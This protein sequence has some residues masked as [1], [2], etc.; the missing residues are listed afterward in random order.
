MQYTFIEISNGMNID[1]TKMFKNLFILPYKH[2][3]Q[4]R[5]TLNTMM[6]LSFINRKKEINNLNQL[7]TWFVANLVTTLD[8]SL[9]FHIYFLIY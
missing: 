4:I 2:Q 5:F 1:D 8:T 9:P 6:T 7:K 3:T